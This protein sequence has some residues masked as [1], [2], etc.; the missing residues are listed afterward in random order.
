[1]EILHGNQFTITVLENN[2]F[3]LRFPAEQLIIEEE[4][5]GERSLRKKKSVVFGLLPETSRRAKTQL[6]P[7]E[8]EERNRKVTFEIYEI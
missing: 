3:Y 6:T 4:I 5:S 7:E 1:M 8:I 2:I